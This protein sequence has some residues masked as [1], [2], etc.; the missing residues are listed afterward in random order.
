MS[1]DGRRRA[2][3]MVIEVSRETG[4]R[5]PRADEVRRVAAL[6]VRAERGRLASLSIALV[7]NATIARLNRRFLGHRGPTDVISF[8][9]PGPGG[10]A[11]DIYIAPAVARTAAA[12]LGIP[13]REEI[14]RLV[15]HGVL[16]VLGH[17]H[18]DGEARL[19]SAM[20]RRQEAILGRALRAPGHRP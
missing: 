11:G 5:A 19:R 20:W 2:P 4:V 13:A 14:L 3:A 7:S 12:A 1:A 10:D 6:A 8:T 9:L 17:D 15:V 18:P 16:H